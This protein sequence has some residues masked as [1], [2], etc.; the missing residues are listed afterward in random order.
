LSGLAEN[1]FFS[2][3]L[4]SCLGNSVRKRLSLAL[5]RAFRG[6]ARPLG[7]PGQDRALL[8]AQVRGRK[9]PQ[10]VQTF[11]RSR[12]PALVRTLRDVMGLY[13][14]PPANASTT[15]S[16]ALLSGP[17]APPGACARRGMGRQR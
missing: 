11:Q 5:R 17:R 15:I 14:N 12:V 3:L 2:I 4:A 6:L 8:R 16:P 13:L 7:V 10:R 1:E 9:T